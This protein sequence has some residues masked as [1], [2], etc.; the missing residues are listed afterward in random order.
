M[1]FPNTTSLKRAQI[2]AWIA[3]LG[4]IAGIALRPAGEDG[5]WAILMLVLLFDL[6][7]IIVLNWWIRS[8]LAATLPPAKATPERSLIFVLIAALTWGIIDAFFF[9]QG[10]ISFI[11]CVAGVLY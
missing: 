3:L 11:L 7:V 9:G 4:C 5:F 1:P 8:R 6:I 2:A 10:V